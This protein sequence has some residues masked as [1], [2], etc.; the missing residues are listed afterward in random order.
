MGRVVEA[1]CLDL[2]ADAAPSQLGPGGSANWRSNV[3]LPG[4][5]RTPPGVIPK[6]AGSGFETSAYSSL[7]PRSHFANVPDQHRS[8]APLRSA[9]SQES[10]GWFPLLNG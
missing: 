1:T 10:S 9:T 5:T 6:K 4:A 8:L 7:F 2:R 3:G